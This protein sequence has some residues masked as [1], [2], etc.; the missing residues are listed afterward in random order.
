MISEHPIAIGNETNYIIF[1]FAVTDMTYKPRP[2]IIEGKK[3]LTT[4]YV[5]SNVYPA[6]HDILLANTNYGKFPIIS[7]VYVAQLICSM[8]TGW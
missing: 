4:Y 1:N 6:V 3:S 8:K 5:L 7:P 2:P